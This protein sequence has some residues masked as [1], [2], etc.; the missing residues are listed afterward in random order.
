MVAVGLILFYI[1]LT[2]FAEPLGW[3]WTWLSSPAVPRFF[4]YLMLATMVITVY[5]GIDYL[6]RSGSL[7]KGLLK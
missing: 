1:N 2:T 7:W 4:D 5:T 6:W 3:H